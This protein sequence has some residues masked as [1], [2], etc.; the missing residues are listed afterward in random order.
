MMLGIMVLSSLVMATALKYGY[1]SLTELH[2]GCDQL[3]TTMDHK[4]V[5]E[6]L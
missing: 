2:G 6:I 3:D 1:N 5:L 4:S